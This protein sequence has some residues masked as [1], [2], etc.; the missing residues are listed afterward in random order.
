MLATA[1]LLKAK[2]MPSTSTQMPPSVPIRLMM[3]F[4]LERRGFTVTSGI[5]ATAGERNTDI[6]AS[7]TTRISINRIRWVG[8]C[9]VSV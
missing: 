9:T 2:P 1:L 7:T 5:S 4:A 6:A 3:A 8:F